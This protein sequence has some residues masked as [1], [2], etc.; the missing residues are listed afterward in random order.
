VDEFLRGK[1]HINARRRKMKIEIH[2][3]EDRRTL[4]ISVNGAAPVP[5][6]NFI[7][8]TK[9]GEK[10]RNI[11][12]GASEAVGRLIYWL[13]VN[14]WRFEE[15]AM[16]DVLERVAGDIHDSREIRNT[17]SEDTVLK[18]HVEEWKQ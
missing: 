16:R 8:L 2:V 10:T 13:Y 7:L 17:A 15:A 6:D 12:F 5:M 4:S 14:S 18:A 11:V 3:S 9:E 1:I